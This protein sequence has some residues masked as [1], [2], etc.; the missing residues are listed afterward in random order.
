MQNVKHITLEAVVLFGIISAKTGKVLLDWP[1]SHEEPPHAVFFNFEEISDACVDF[2]RS[3]VV[4]TLYMLMAYNMIQC[5]FVG[6]GF[7][8]MA[9]VNCGIFDPLEISVD[10]SS[11]PVTRNHPARLGCT[12]N[13][14]A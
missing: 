1:I 13:H 11:G 12:T 9:G 6:D 3:S 7:Y 10:C 14:R 8:A 5:S 2:D 4:E